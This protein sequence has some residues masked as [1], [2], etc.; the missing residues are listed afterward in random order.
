VTFVSY[1]LA[2]QYEHFIV[3]G[4]EKSSKSSSVIACSQFGHGTE[5]LIIN[6]LKTNLNI[7]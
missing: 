2:L 6:L 4:D 7:V 5:V 1:N 3:N